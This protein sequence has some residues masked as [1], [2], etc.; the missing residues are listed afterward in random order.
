MGT[1]CPPMLDLYLQSSDYHRLPN[2]VSRMSCK[3]FTLFSQGTTRLLL[4]KIP[5]FKDVILMS[6]SCP[7]CGESNNEIR[8]AGP[9]QDR[10]IR[11]KTNITGIKVSPF[12]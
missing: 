12:D 9:I 1:T 3:I 11:I 6:F 10:G 2:N 4:T 5:F 7:H 8:P